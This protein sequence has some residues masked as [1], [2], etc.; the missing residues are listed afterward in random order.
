MGEEVKACVQESK[1]HLCNE[2]LPHK[3]TAIST[4]HMLNAYEYCLL[5]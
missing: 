5:V 2:Q 4:A 1:K 3:I